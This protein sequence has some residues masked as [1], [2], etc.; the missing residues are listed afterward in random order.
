MVSP[1]KIMAECL[2]PHF[3]IEKQVLENVPRPII[4]DS[5]RLSNVSQVYDSQT[6]WVDS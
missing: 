1:E 4:Q 3:R 2:T 5:I 6:L